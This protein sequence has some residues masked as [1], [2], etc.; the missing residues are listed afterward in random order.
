VCRLLNVYYTIGEKKQ[1]D[2]EEVQLSL[3]QFI[4]FNLKKKKKMFLLY[5]N[6]WLG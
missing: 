3:R 6:F 4:S 5:F 2:E 1:Q